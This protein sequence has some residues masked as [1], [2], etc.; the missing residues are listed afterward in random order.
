MASHGPN[1]VPTITKAFYIMDTL[2]G[3]VKPPKRKNRP[4]RMNGSNRSVKDPKNKEMP[5]KR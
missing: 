3:E 1:N 2:Y 5:L 4:K